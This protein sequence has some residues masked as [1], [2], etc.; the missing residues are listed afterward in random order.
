MFRFQQEKVRKRRRPWF[1]FPDRS[2]VLPWPT[3]SP[4]FPPR[5]SETSPTSST[6][7]GRMLLSRYYAVEVRVLCGVFLFCFL[8]LDFGRVFCGAGWRNRE[9]VSGGRRS[10]QDYGRDQFVDQ[11]VHILAAGE[12]P[13]GEL[14]GGV[15]NQG[16]TRLTCEV[17]VYLQL[18]LMFLF[19][20]VR[21][22]WLGWRRP[23]LVW[24]VKQLSISR[25]GACSFG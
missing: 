17:F 15:W 23:L 7:S 21:E 9:A 2:R 3:P 10:R 11:W 8:D 1:P 25:Y 5:S 18:V 14:M 24:L 22:D 6:R 4:R 13:E 12:S 20:W 16:F 19:I